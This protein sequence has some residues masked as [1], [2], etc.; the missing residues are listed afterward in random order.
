MRALFFTFKFSKPLP[1]A[2]G[3]NRVAF[4]FID[5]LSNFRSSPVLVF[6]AYKVVEDGKL[7]SMSYAETTSKNFAAATFV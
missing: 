6:D 4:A 1:T 2:S 3:Q 7:I 5:T